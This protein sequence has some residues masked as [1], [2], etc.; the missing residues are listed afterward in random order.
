MGVG[1]RQQRREY[2]Q[3]L[4]GQNRHC[5]YTRDNVQQQK[6]LR[7]GARKEIQCADLRVHL[8]G[9]ERDRHGG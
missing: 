2:H 6:R 7:A 9:T 1:K 5:Q 3:I 8:Q 4:Q